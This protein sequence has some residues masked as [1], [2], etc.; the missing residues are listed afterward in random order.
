MN[1]FAY[2]KARLAES[3]VGMNNIPVGKHHD[4]AW[5]VE[6]VV[7]LQGTGDLAGARHVRALARRCFQLSNHRRFG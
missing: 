1:E 7:T 6:N 3:L 4:Y 5:L 2:Q